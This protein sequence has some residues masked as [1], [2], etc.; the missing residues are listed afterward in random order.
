VLLLA[1]P[2]A[3]AALL[4]CPASPPL[5]LVAVCD[6]PPLLP[7]VELD[8][9]LLELQA[10]PRTTTAPIR[11][12]AQ[13]RILEFMT[14]HHLVTD[15]EYRIHQGSEPEHDHVRIQTHGSCS[16][17]REHCERDHPLSLVSAG[18]ELTGSTTCAGGRSPCLRARAIHS[19]AAPEAGV[20]TT[21]ALIRPS[22]TNRWP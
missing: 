20:M 19:M 16:A 7:A 5:L 9:L 17:Q 8:A 10:Q 6:C 22:R 3:P 11:Q 13:G 4:V 1:P 14:A 15:G 18:N 2:E 12:S 21:V